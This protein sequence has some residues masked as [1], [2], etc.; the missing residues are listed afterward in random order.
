M[1]S[2]V[3][4]E[5]ALALLFAQFVEVADLQKGHVISVMELGE[6]EESH[7]FIAGMG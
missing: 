7:V 3:H 5:T 6:K 2:S 4:I 1:S